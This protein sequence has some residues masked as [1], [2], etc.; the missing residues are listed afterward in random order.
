MNKTHDYSMPAEW[1]EHERT[2]IEW[3]VR[4]SMVWPENHEEVC[5]AY[6]EVVNMVSG[7]EK[8]TVIVNRDSEAEARKLCTSDAEFV[9]IPHNDA[10]CRDNGPT[11]GHRPGRRPCRNKLAVQRMGRKIHPLRPGQQGCPCHTETLRRAC[12]QFTH[13][14]GGRLHS[15]GR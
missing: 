13:C 12:H 6:A 15:R 11:F 14:T 5:R 3:P 7:F 10:W 9:T 4:E 2:I 8:V 1:E